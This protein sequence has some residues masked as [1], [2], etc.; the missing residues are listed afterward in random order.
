MQDSVALTSDDHSWVLVNASPDV[1]RQIQTNPTLWPRTAR[2]SPIKAIV[3]TNGDVDHVLGLF[4][5]REAQPLSVYAT[6]H[7][8]R[9]LEQNLL[10]R[11]L[12]R[13]TGHVEFR[14]LPLGEPVNI[15]GI[16]GTTTGVVVRAFAAEG[17]PPIHLA[18]AFAPHPEDNI[19]LLVES[20][21]GGRV[22]YVTAARSTDAIAESVAGSS[23]LL[24]DGTFFSDDELP[25]QGL[26]AA[27]ARDMA[28]VPIGGADGSLVSLRELRV[29][30]RV[31]SHINN[32]NPILNSHSSER[33]LVESSG[34]EVGYDG[35][36][37]VVQ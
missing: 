10:L 18:A 24:F 3:L 19:G 27:R 2:D 8:L 9:G 36:E 23:A 11:T 6:E 12:Q 1:L 20:A 4:A 17:K 14:R 5:L 30:R 25:R 7:V 13:F 16:N 29:A 35:L 32:T 33:R 22:A 21:T 31:Y 26:G 28:H 37:I 15:E 34:W